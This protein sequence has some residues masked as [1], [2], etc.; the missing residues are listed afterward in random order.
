VATVLLL[1]DGMVPPAARALA[2]WPRLAWL[3]LLPAVLLLFASRVACRQAD[4]C[5][6]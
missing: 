4:L 5:V 3:A 1:R 2:R 6:F